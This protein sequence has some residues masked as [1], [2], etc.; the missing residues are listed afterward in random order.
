MN[1]VKRSVMLAGAASLLIV[2]LAFGQATD[3][4]FK[5]ESKATQGS[6]KF[7]GAKAKCVIK[8]LQG[9]WKGLNPET[10]CAPPYAGATAVC[11]SDPLKGAEAKFVANTRKNCDPAFKPGT[12]C[13]ECY[14]GGDCTQYAEDYMQTIEGQVDS[15]VPGVGCEL[16][17][18]T[19]AEQKCQTNTAK[20][21][22]KQSAGVV[23]CYTKCFANAHKGI[24]SAAACFPATESVTVAC[25]AGV[26]GKTVASVNKLCGDIGAS[27]DNCGGPYNDG[28]SWAN[29]VDIAISGNIPGNFC[30]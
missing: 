17:G 24:G 18:A 10:D 26:V 22:A 21:L 7:V 20:A 30:E 16:A 27:P 28:A 1:N 14:N 15:F 6:T 3:A 12:D 13:P 29:L 25:I 11:V 23:K 9:F 5:C 8:C 4:E 2:P 19:P